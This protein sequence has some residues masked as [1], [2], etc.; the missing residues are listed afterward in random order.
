MDYYPPQE[1]YPPGGYPGGGGYPPGGGYPVGGYPAAGGY[2]GG[3][4]PFQIVSDLNGKVLDIRGGASFPGTPVIMFSRKMDRSPN[5]L[6]YL[7]EMGC[8]RSMMNEFA[9]ECRAQGERLHMEPY[10]G[11][12]RQQWIIQGNR[13]VNRIYPVECLDIE[14]AEQRDEANV[15]AWPYNGGANQHWRFDYV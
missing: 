3:R 12:P 4:R 5:Q 6:W 15:I 11:D 8:I 10:R 7:D 9:P 2:P 14:R 1:G 13:I